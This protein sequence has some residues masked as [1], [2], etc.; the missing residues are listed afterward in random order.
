MNFECFCNAMALQK[1]SIKINPPQD[2]GGMG[3]VDNFM[4]YRIRLDQDTRGTRIIIVKQREEWS[5]AQTNRLRAFLN[6]GTGLNPGS[7]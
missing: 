1:H 2:W 4:A 7:C 5:H 3:G 6:I